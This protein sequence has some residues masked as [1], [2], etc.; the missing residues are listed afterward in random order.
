MTIIFI[1]IVCTLAI[2]SLTDI[3]RRE[4]TLVGPL[5]IASAGIIEIFMGNQSMAGALS[6]LLIGAVFYV[7]AVIT[8]ESIGKGDAIFLGCLGIYLGLERLLYI[9]LITGMALFLSAAV[10]FAIKRNRKQKLPMIPFIFVGFLGGM[11]IE[12]I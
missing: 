3:R 11:L 10:L 1:I 8:G 2:L 9:M 4:V 5:I 6:G 7:A 12:K